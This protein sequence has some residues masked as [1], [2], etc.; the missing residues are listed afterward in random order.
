MGAG[1]SGLSCAI[2][3]EKH[4]IYPTIFEDRRQVGDRFVSGEIFLSILNRPIQDTMAYL[5]EKH[6]IFLHPTSN[7]KK[8][9]IYSKNNKSTI[10]GK[11]GFT[12][13]RGRHKE[14]LEKQLAKQVKSKIIFNSDYTYE[15]LQREYTHVILATGDAAY[16]SQLQHYREDLTVTLK[17][18]TVEGNFN[19]KRVIAWLDYDFAP[20]G[21]GYLIPYNKKE[22]NIVIGYPDYPENRKEGLDDLWNRFYNRVCKNLDQNIRLTDN[23]QITRYIVGICEEP[24]IGNTFFVGNCFGSIMPFLGFGQLM[25]ILTGIY[26]AKDLAGEGDYIKLTKDLRKDYEAS[27]TL[28]RYLETLDNNDIDKLVSKLNG[29]MGDRLFNTKFDPLKYISYLLKLFTRNNKR[30]V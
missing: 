22:A 29:K 10:E 26:A 17:G 19:T 12:N 8:L 16:A 23:F 7:I 30:Q 6:N 24:R 28:R 21:Y 5:S 15:Q 13:I 4:G 27:L 1:L 9:D 18:A 25:A 14:A 3:L 11:L 20:K 2:E